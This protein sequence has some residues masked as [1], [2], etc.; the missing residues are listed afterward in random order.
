MAEQKLRQ[1]RP[2]TV[3]S[4][5]ICGRCEKSHIVGCDADG[6]IGSLICP[7]R[8]LASR[9]SDSSRSDTAPDDSEEP[10]WRCPAVRSHGICGAFNDAEDATCGACG[11]AKP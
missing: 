6:L 9:P 2:H 11:E 7:N 4:N 8:P 3:G 1:V 10:L 5:Y